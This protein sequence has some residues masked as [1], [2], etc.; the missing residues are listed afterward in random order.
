MKIL[1]YNLGCGKQFG[2]FG[3][4]NPYYTLLGTELRFL[5]IH[6]IGAVVAT[7][8]ITGLLYVLKRRGKVSISNAFWQPHYI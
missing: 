2:C 7:A 4:E 5:T 1:Q 3:P 6:L 8:L